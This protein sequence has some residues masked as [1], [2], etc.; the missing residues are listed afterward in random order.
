MVNNFREI[1][2]DIINSPHEYI[3]DRGKIK[4]KK[5]I[6]YLCTN[7]PEELIYAAGI[8]PVRILG[9]NEPE[10]ITDEHLFQAALCSFSR[11]CFAQCLKGNY[12]YLD[13]IVYG[14]GCMHTRQVF[15]VWQNQKPSA[16]TYEL[17]VPT[18]LH[19]PEAEQFLI[20]EIQD[21]RVALEKWAEKDISN[22]DIDRAIDI[23]NTNRRLVLSI[24]ELMKADEPPLTGA[25][26]LR[27]ALTGMLIDKEDHNMLLE[28]VLSE[29]SS[30]KYTG[31]YE[32]RLMLIG[33]VNNDFKLIEMIENCGARIVID[34]YCTG[35][36]YYQAPVVPSEDRLAALASRMVDQPP[37]PLKD[38]SEDRRRVAHISNLIDEYGVEGVVYTIQRRCDS[39]GLDYPSVQEMTD[40][41]GIPML[42]LELDFSSAIAQY[43]TRLEAF[44]EMLGTS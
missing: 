24:Y 12:D 30:I 22:S 31:K 28:D 40:S 5:V 16:F 38:L 19:N 2:R 20:G 14:L 41:K 25:E 13:G 36:R 8:L 29:L 43:R 9:S 23:Y 35:N 7:I 27:I 3:K 11:D 37:C 4:Q 42:K 39:H 33:S 34:D 15:Q 17:Q 6:G 44:I 26:L 21:F 10:N 1:F 32:P 18:L